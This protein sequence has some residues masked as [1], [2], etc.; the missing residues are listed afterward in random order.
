VVWDGETPWTATELLHAQGDAADDGAAR[1]SVV[2]EARDWLRAALAAGPRP[3]SELRQEAAVRGI[4]YNALAAAR[5][6][7]GV[8]AR[9]E[10]V[11]RGL[12]LWTLKDQNGEEVQTL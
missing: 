2:E 6:A 11:A 7:E 5:K 1:R 10:R 12:W 8:I 3:A 9:K 4:G